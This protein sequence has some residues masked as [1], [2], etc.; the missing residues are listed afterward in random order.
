MIPGSFSFVAS[1]AMITRILMS[2]TKLNK[3]NRRIIFAMS[4][5]D[6][7]AATAALTSGM[8]SPKG[9]T[10]LAIGNQTTCSV[11][12]FINQVRAMSFF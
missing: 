5:L 1:S 12:G 3:P 11:Q 8:P 7:L 4:L 2:K 10:I 9:T 6:L